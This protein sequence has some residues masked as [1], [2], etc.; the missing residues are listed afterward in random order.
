MTE[1]NAEKKYQSF[2]I[3]VSPQEM[4]TLEARSER[5]DM[6]IK[7][8]IKQSALRKRISGYRLQP[9]TQHIMAIDEIVRTVKSISVVPHMDRWL[10]EKDLE[11]IDRKLD[12]LISVEKSIQE[13][14]HRRIS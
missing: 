9:L 2:R 5:V 1:A 14:L 13:L 11:T 8:F 10:Y 12:E 7:Q 3:K 4:N 6:D